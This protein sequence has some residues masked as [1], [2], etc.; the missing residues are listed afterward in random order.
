MRV[1]DTAESRVVRALTPVLSINRNCVAPITLLSKAPARLVVRERIGFLALNC[2]VIMSSRIHAVKVLQELALLKF[3]VYVIWKIS[4]EVV[5]YCD[6]F[7]PTSIFLA[8]ARSLNLQLIIVG[9]LFPCRKCN[10]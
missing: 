2:G 9:I 7:G 5:H 10:G 3:R 4:D 8:E 1:I 6:S